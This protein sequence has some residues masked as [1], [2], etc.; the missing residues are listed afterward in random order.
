MA[1]PGGF[2]NR[3]QREPASSGATDPVRNRVVP[4]I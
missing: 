1:L 2:V 4:V 3:D